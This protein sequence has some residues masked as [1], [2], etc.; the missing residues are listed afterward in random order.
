MRTWQDLNRIM[1]NEANVFSFARRGDLEG[2]KALSISRECLNDK[3]A[4][5]Y[6]PLMLAVYH[7]HQELAAYF[8]CLGADPNSVDHSGNSILMVAAFKGHVAIVR[9]LVE[10]GAD[11]DAKNPK[12]H[13]A[14]DFAQMF[15]RHDVVRYLNENTRPKPQT[16]RFRRWLDYS[17][18]FWRVRPVPSLRLIL[19]PKPKGEA[20]TSSDCET[21]SSVRDAAERP[22]PRPG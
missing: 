9:L 19:L 17:T 13:V 11:I 10:H 20:L 6:S 8:L 4:K 22:L 7:G 21:R 3:D 14:K 1:R 2:L 18:G 15:A 5:G 16:S 12:G